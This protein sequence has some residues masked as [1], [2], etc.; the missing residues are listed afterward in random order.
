MQ[1][2]N[3]TPQ[4]ESENLDAQGITESPATDSPS[5]E[6]SEKLEEGQSPEAISREEYDKLQK[7]LKKLEMERNHLRNK[8]EEERRK[9]LE[10]SN[11]FKTLYE[12]TQ[13]KLAEIEAQKEAEETLKSAQKLRES[14]I[15]EYPDEAVRKAA[16]ALIERNPSNI[17][18]GDVETEDQAKTQIFEQLDALKETLG[19]IGSEDTEEPYP[20]INPNNPATSQGNPELDKLKSLSSDELRKVLPH[21]DIR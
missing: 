1:T 11:E 8:Q 15:N 7:E 6:E 3:E 5:V 2:E 12:E 21:A 10:E 4:G 16:K 18:W 9:Q 13:A 20:Q 19:I 14:F 17:A